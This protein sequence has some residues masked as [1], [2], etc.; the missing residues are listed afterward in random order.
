VPRLTRK[1]GGPAIFADY[2]DNHVVWP[3]RETALAAF[4][5]KTFAGKKHKLA[6]ARSSHSEDALTWSC[7]DLLAQLPRANAEQAMSEMWALAYDGAAL[8]EAVRS[9]QFFVGRDFGVSGEKTEV[10]AG[11]ESSSA[12]VFIEAKLYSAMS[13][14][15]LPAKPYNQIVRKLRVG[16]REAAK[17]GREFY[18]IVLDVAPAHELKAIRPGASLAEAKA[19]RTGGFAGKWLTGYWFLRYKA[20]RKGSTKPLAEELARPPAIEKVNVATVMRNMGWL[21]WADVTKATMRALVRE[22]QTRGQGPK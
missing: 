17:T 9:G 12:L 13:Q 18:F 11:I 4:V 19:A 20:S 22:I 5:E 8:P 1:K 3:G 16:L 10:D 7:F 14:A 2:R 15:D 21:T 6:N